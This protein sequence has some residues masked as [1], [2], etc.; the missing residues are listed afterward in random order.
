MY[1]YFPKL[2]SV[3]TC[4]PF[5]QIIHVDS[6]N[7][8]EYKNAFVC[9]KWEKEDTMDGKF[10]LFY[11]YA[12]TCDCDPLSDLKGHVPDYDEYGCYNCGRPKVGPFKEGE[13]LYLE[14]C[15]SQDAIW[16]TPIK[17]YYNGN[18]K[19]YEVCEVHGY[20]NVYKWANCDPEHQYILHREKNGRFS[21][22]NMYDTFKDNLD[23]CE[24]IFT[25]KLI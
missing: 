6:M 16:T 18:V 24:I 9:D 8:S 2:N 13:K 25:D 3:L 21:D 15:G 11:K 19:A 20:P 5:P 23:N 14:N 17:P 4:E 10:V 1:I 22:I 7:D 12:N